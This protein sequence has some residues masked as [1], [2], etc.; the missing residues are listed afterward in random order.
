MV[1]DVVESSRLMA[2]DEAR[3][4]AAIR[5]FKAKTLMPLVTE[6][7]GDVLKHMG[8][9]WIVAFT[10]TTAAVACAMAVQTKLVDRAPIKLRIG[11]HLVELV[12]DDTDFHGTGVNVAARLQAEAP[13]GGL[14]VSQDVHRQLTGSLASAFVDAGAFELKHISLPVNGFQW[15]PPAVDGRNA[16]DVPSIG[17]DPFDHDPDDRDTRAAA[18]DLRDQ[19]VR[20]LARRTGVRVVDVAADAGAAPTYRLRGRLRLAAGR[21]RLHLALSVAEDGRTAWSETY[22]EDPRDIFAFADALVERAD[23]ALRLQINAFDGDRLAHLPE[24]ALSVS[25][26]RARA[27]AGFYKPTLDDWMETRRLLER[28]LALIPDDPM[29]L[30]MRA[31][32]T[33]MLAAARH[34]E[35]AGEL[36]EALEQEL[37]HAV[38]RLPR[39][40]YALF[41]RA[42][43]A[44]FVH[45]DTTSAFRDLDRT[46]ALTP[47][48]APGLEFRGLAHLRAREPAAA[49]VELERAVDVSEGDPLLPCRLFML[50]LAHH[51]ADAPERGLAAIERAIQERPSQRNYH[52]LKAICAAAAGDDA[53][54]RAAERRA[55]TLARTPSILAPRPP[56]PPEHAGLARRFAP[57]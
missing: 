7:G 43:F 22:E 23:A 40:D 5:A 18:R 48:Y 46:L 13:P 32:A 9:G 31:E 21:G 24:D 38:E 2:E 35:L 53:A 27:A 51:L 25:E 1:A 56:L 12:H 15:R 44:V 52:V 30:A 16:G 19:L 34:E 8:D 50:A 55:H 29:A 57:A 54:R 14:M 47:S 42:A 49:A 41:V 3:A 11:A 10:S 37:D 20:R 17:V 33:I 4:I 6:H 28:A 45:G 39:S 26:L 36:A